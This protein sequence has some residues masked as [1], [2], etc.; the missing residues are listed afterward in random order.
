MTTID[1]FFIIAV[2]FW[3]DWKN[4]SAIDELTEEVNRL[5]RK[6]K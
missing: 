3:V 4:S 2:V 1:L 6:I 5:K